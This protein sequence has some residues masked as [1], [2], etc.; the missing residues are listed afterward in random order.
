ML[1][2]LGILPVGCG[3]NFVTSGMEFGSRVVYAVLMK[4]S[5]W[6][7]LV[8]VLMACAWVSRKPEA[9]LEVERISPGMTLEEAGANFFLDPRPA[10]L[11]EEYRGVILGNALVFLD[12]NDVVVGVV[13]EYAR[14]GQIDLANG[15]YVDE[16][17]RSLGFDHV[18]EFQKVYRFQE[19]G[20]YCR[21][22]KHATRYFAGQVPARYLDFGLPPED[23]AST[24]DS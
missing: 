21:D 7:A 16:V 5:H 19:L 15:E 22:K 6:V 8:V 13:G 3:V 9:K 20:V 18:G 14:M 2:G 24:P 11:S 17:A 1:G 4:S 12:S 23:G 10:G